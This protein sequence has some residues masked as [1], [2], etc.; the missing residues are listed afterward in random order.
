MR[1]VIGIFELLPSEIKDV[2]DAS[3]ASDAAVT[4]VA[5]VFDDIGSGKIVDDLKNVPGVIVSDITSAWG[6]LTAGLGDGWG[7][8]T[9]FLGCIFGPCPHTTADAYTCHGLGATPTSAGAASA[10]RIEIKPE[11][12][13]T[14]QRSNATITAA[15]TQSPLITPFPNQTL[16]LTVSTQSPQP[17]ASAEAGSGAMHMID[18]PRVIQLCWIFAVGVLGVALLL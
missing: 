10:D 12:K 5:K 7:A 3:D 15:P 14:F 17:S 13:T 2:A 11:S 18:P 16:L 6:D 4:N 1:D 9:G 8:A